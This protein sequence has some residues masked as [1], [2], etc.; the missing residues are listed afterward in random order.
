MRK[1]LSVILGIS[2]IFTAF[3][4]IPASA[5]A[6]TGESSFI[7]FDEEYYATGEGIANA[8]LD[9]E[10]FKD[11]EH[12][13][14]VKY[15]MLS[16][17]GGKWPNAIRL[18]D[19]TGKAPFIFEKGSCYVISL[20]MKKAVTGNAMNI[21]LMALQ[22]YN[23]LGNANQNFKNI[24]FEW[25][26]AAATDWVTITKVIDAN[27][28]DEDTA[29]FALTLF[30][31]KGPFDNQEIYFDNI[32]IQK[33]SNDSTSVNFNEGLYN[34]D[35]GIFGAVLDTETFKNDEKYETVAKYTQISK[36]TS[37]NPG[38]W[39][40]AVR[41][42][43]STGN[44]PFVFKKG[45]L[46]E[47][48]F[49]LKAVKADAAF[50]VYLAESTGG[51]A[52]ITIGN[53]MIYHSWIGGPA[54]W[55]KYTAVI[56]TSTLVNDSVSMA[57]VLYTSSGIYKE[58]EIYID[59]ISVNRIVNVT[60]NTN[61]GAAA[62][63]K[64]YTVGTPISDI[65]AYLAGAELEGWYYDAALEKPASGDTVT[66]ST[67]TLYAKWKSF[68][69]DADNYIG[70]NLDNSVSVA[71]YAGYANSNAYKTEINQNDTWPTR[72]L[73]LN[74]D[75]KELK[76]VPGHNYLL[77][78]KVKVG[79]KVGDKPISWTSSISVANSGGAYS[80]DI[81]YELTN[82][83]E[84]NEIGNTKA[85]IQLGNIFGVTSDL[86]DTE[87]K[88]LTF[89]FKAGESEAPVY[90]TTR[91]V[92]GSTYFDDISITDLTAQYNATAADGTVL[93]S[94]YYG[95]SFTVPETDANGDTNRLYW[96]KT[97][98]GP[99]FTGGMLTGDITLYPVTSQ[100]ALTKTE[101]L[102]KNSKPVLS[103]KLRFEGVE[104][105]DNKLNFITIGN[106]RYIVSEV[107]VI[108]APSASLGENRLTAENYSQYGGKILKNSELSYT[109]FENGALTVEL[110][111]T[112]NNAETDYSVVGY[113]KYGISGKTLYSK[114]R[115]GLKMSYLSAAD[116]EKTNLYQV[117]Y[118]GNTYTLTFNSEFNDGDVYGK[119]SS[120]SDK[121]TD[122]NGNVKYAVPQMAT[123]SNGRLCMK[124]VKDGSVMQISELQTNRLFT[125]GYIEFKAQ[126]A[127][128]SDVAGAVWLLSGGL[129][130][131]ELTVKP[132]GDDTY[133]LPEIDIIEFGK[134]SQFSSTLHSWER[135]TG[136]RKMNCVSIDKYFKTSNFTL[137]KDTRTLNV[138]LSKEHTYGFERTSDVMRFYVDGV[139][140]F[141][142]NKSDIEK[143][144][145]DNKGVDV[146]TANEV[147]ALFDNPVYLRL[148]ASFGFE[149]NVESAE[150]YIDYV[151]IYE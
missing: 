126:Y 106:T 79:D 5:A 15:T 72:L 63:T 22:P 116:L 39:P 151:R 115:D 117:N 65:K 87:Y 145:P 84:G 9:K 24:A 137:D 120:R 141:D 123:V 135:G 35:T 125:H 86:T 2:I 134:S 66:A 6:E 99:A 101:A 82:P 132:L 94:G 17:D 44:N 10:T 12:G 143:A 8:Q 69:Y 53:T 62:E 107:G 46:Y 13:T 29:T 112:V 64:E 57:L 60:L 18:A 78:L 21:C 150:S 81:L 93:A 105:E 90:I 7:T 34:T 42:A 19:S 36:W 136:K 58:Q 98:N 71:E 122:N 43:D 77:T 49:D 139:L 52:S 108:V 96:S 3:A 40:N 97:Q 51:L 27:F 76:T 54:D 144:Y 85:Y 100:I 67:G 83:T 32:R 4:V 80:T 142:V 111:I 130:D 55:Q 113:V 110:E 31:S 33:I 74:K 119:F 127:N 23:G 109:A 140:V 118:N 148:G 68:N 114:A 26:S 70:T 138:D 89:N 30:Q 102:V 88:T 92:G 95:E 50:N 28:F 124:S 131:D 25:V 45:E 20:D 14:V 128:V 91:L 59:N 104:C 73:L 133:V 56:D 149:S 48:S 1:L 129:A 146:R 47:V 103:A 121:F 16:K 38:K 75:G 147:R 37:D 41:I 61:N 11:T